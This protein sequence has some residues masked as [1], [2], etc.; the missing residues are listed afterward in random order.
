MVSTYSSLTSFRSGTQVP[1]EYAAGLSQQFAETAALLKT[2]EGRARYLQ[3][4]ESHK[5]KTVTEDELKDSG[6]VTAFVSRGSDSAQVGITTH[7]IYEQTARVA[8]LISH[9]LGQPDRP[10]GFQAASSIVRSLEY[11]VAQLGNAVVGE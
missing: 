8:L 4:I 5:G 1:M 2:P 6:V 7:P 3:D 11:A 10:A 9:E